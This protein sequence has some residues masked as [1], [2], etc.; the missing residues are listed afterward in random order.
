MKLKNKY[1]KQNIYSN[2]KFEDQIWYN[3]QIMTFLN[4]SQL[5]ESVFRPNFPGKHFPEKPSQIFLWLESVFRW[6]TFLMANKH[7]KVWKVVSRKPLSGKQTQPKEKILSWKPS[8]IFLW[9]ENVFRW[10]E[11]IFLWLESIFCWSESIFCLPSFLI[12]NKHKKIWNVFWS[13][14]KSTNTKFFLQRFL[15]RI[16]CIRILNRVQRKKKF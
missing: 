6:P 12:A 14:C 11:N 9:L 7:M 5:P 1:S 16:A 13:I 3:Q 15:K 10:P 2:Q 8:K 4:F